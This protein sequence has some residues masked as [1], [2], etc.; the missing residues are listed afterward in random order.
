[1]LKISTKFHRDHA[2]RGAE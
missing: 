2:K 1:M